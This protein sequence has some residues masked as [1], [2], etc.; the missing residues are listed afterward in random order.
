MEEHKAS[1]NLSEEQ[2]ETIVQQLDKLYELQELKKNGSESSSGS[3]PPP[4]SA[5]STT[6]DNS[7]RTQPQTQS[8][9]N[10]SRTS[11]NVPQSHSMSSSSNSARSDRLH[12]P[13]R[14]PPGF[15]DRGRERLHRGRPPRHLLPT[16]FDPLYP[17]DDRDF[18]HGP[19][20][21]PPPPHDHPDYYRGRPPR[22]GGFRPHRGGPPPGWLERGRG[23][24]YDGPP[25]GR[26]RALPGPPPPHWHEP[27]DMEQ[28]G[29]QSYKFMYIFSSFETISGPYP[30]HPHHLLPSHGPPP[31]PDMLPPPILVHGPPPP[32]PKEADSTIVSDL[33]SKLVN[34]GLIGGEGS[35]NT[36]PPGPA[37]APGSGLEGGAS[38]P[39]VTPP[40]MLRQTPPPPVS[41]PRLGLTPA[42]LK[43]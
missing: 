43:Q 17:P 19:L 10:D 21:P 15:R 39:R 18:P 4:S 14:P 35:E 1:G 32:P 8:R 6:T 3:P 20:P 29:E 25:H 16:P 41:V 22:R 5:D 33:L 12:D 31:P 40:R 37:P 26:G 9:E 11:K 30:P 38:G 28:N 27:V 2:H 7:S 13:N 34:A 42:T 36:P 23:R 24:Y